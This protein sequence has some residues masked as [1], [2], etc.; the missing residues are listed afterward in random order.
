MKQKFMRLCAFLIALSLLLV[1][2]VNGGEG[3]SVP[4]TEYADAPT[5]ES[6]NAPT[7][8]PSAPVSAVEHSVTVS[9]LGG[10]VLSKVEIRV[11]A[12]A[13]LTDLI[14]AGKTDTNGRF[15]FKRIPAEG[16]VAVLNKLPTGYGAQDYYEL[17]GESTNISLAP[18]IVSQEDLHQMQFRLGD[19]IPDFSLT[20]VDGRVYTLSD[21][22]QNK[23]A[24]VLNFWY[25][26]CEPCKLEFP[27][28]QEAYEKYAEDITFLA[29]NPMDS[30]NQEISQ[31]MQDNGYTFPMMKVDEAWI[32]MFS[33]TSFPLTVV[34]D[35]F[36]NICLM[37]SGGVPD[38]AAFENLFAYF[39]AEEYTQQ[40]F[41]SINLLPQI[42]E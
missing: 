42:G 25:M 29:V 10:N 22:L 37:H 23:N 9:N 31:F 32:R 1:G 13:T 15:T 33:I 19:A 17:T 7:T 11:Y 39:A 38:S 18:A 28:I 12:D 3:A 14:A 20:G 30:N 2:C 41:K 4:T 6:T 5:T 27:H 26:G 40:F 21:M 35:R 34:I 8:E 24:V 16:Y 36:G